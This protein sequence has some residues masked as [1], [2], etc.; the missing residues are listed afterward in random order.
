MENGIKGS[1]EVADAI[2]W[3]HSHVILNTTIYVA[4]DFLI[5]PTEPRFL[6]LT[7]Q[8]VLNWCKFHSFGNAVRKSPLEVMDSL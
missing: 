8:S 1:H 5:S 6:G 7:S 3:L 4:F 2:Q